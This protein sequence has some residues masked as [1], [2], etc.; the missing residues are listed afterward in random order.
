MN[1]RAISQV[2][3]LGQRWSTACGKLPKEE[4]IYCC[5][6]IVLYTV[7]I[8][9]LINLSLGSSQ[10]SLWASLLSGSVGYILPAPKI[11]KKKDVS[12][13]PDTAEQ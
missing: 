1:S 7:I 4:V 6:I 11:Q 2:S 5:Q 9:C 13:L 12:L 8:A 10:D 3:E